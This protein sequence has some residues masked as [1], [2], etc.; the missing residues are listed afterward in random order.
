VVG[1]EPGRVLLS[2]GSFLTSDTTRVVDWRSTAGNKAYKGKAVFSAWVAPVTGDDATLPFSLSAQLYIRMADGSLQAEGSTVTV[3]YP[4]GTFGAM[5]C[6]G[7]QEIWMTFS[8]NQPSTLGSTEHIGIRV[9]NS[10]TSG[11]GK[12]QRLRLA[13]DVVD[14][15]FAYLTVPE[16]P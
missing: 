6:P 3:D 5:G 2:G 8:V 11:D 13:Y 10:A 4:A 16:K 12:M 7:W 9:W 15:F 1:G 14:D